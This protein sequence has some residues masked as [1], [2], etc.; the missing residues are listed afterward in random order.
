MAYFSLRGVYLDF[1]NYFTVYRYSFYVGTLWILSDA[2][3]CLM[4]LQGRG[5]GLGASQFPRGSEA[6]I[7]G[8]TVLQSDSEG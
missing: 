1:R 4:Q 7:H 3:S 5:L 6:S 8:G 2:L